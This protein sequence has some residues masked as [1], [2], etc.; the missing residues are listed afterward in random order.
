MGTALCTLNAALP[1]VVR[2]VFEHNGTDFAQSLNCVALLS[3][4]AIPILSLKRVLVKPDV[5][6]ETLRG[7]VVLYNGE[8]K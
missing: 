5:P 3:L 4:A 1:C 8:G 6:A 2:R 7:V